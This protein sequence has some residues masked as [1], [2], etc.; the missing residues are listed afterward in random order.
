MKNLVAYLMES[1]KKY[2]GSAPT[3]SVFVDALQA[4]E[5]AYDS[6]NIRANSIITEFGLADLAS[7]PEIQ[8]FQSA[9]KD[10]F[11]AKKSFISRVTSFF[12][13]DDFFNEIGDAFDSKMPKWYEPVLKSEQVAYDMLCKLINKYDGA[14]IVSEALDA[15][16]SYTPM[17]ISIERA[18]HWWDSIKDVEDSEEKMFYKHVVFWD[19]VFA[20]CDEGNAWAENLCKRSETVGSSME[21]SEKFN[22]ELSTTKE[23]KMILDGISEIFKQSEDLTEFLDV[24]LKPIDD[25][26][27]PSEWSLS[28]SDQKAYQSL[29][30]KLENTKQKFIDKCRKIK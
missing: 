20:L 6:I 18:L 22:R 26:D 24:N 1:K 3:L 5:S 2:H 17:E 27:D 16:R 30:K 9:V 8:D 7:I 29:L 19:I 11:D 12:S 14:E 10:F 4:T 25:E 23:F 28:A 21:E 13:K 15:N